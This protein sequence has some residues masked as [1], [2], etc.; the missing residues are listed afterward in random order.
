M[1]RLIAAVMLCVM[2]SCG[3][4]WA[5]APASARIVDFLKIQSMTK[6]GRYGVLTVS[7]SSDASNQLALSA[8][9][10]SVQGQQP[11]AVF[12]EE[13]QQSLR[14]LLPGERFEMHEIVGVQAWPYDSAMG[15]TW[16]TMRFVTSYHG[17]VAVV[18]Q[19]AEGETVLPAQHDAY[20]RVLATF[21]VELMEE[22]R[23]AQPALIAVISL[24]E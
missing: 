19:T 12:A 17:D 16:V 15:E 7:P 2:L 11:I 23:D 14:E 1:K 24:G 3:I 21:P 4:A 10:L 5:D 20:G 13:T 22:I 8:F 6:S 9:G 18:V